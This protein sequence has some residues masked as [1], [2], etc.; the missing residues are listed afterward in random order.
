[1]RA[2]SSAHSDHAKQPAWPFNSA[3]EGRKYNM[4]IEY[5]Q[6][7]T[8]G[9]VIFAI[10]M[11]LGISLYLSAEH[12]ATILIDGA[13]INSSNRYS[14]IIIL[15]GFINFC[16]YLYGAFFLN[17]YSKRIIEHSQYPPPGSNI[18]FTIKLLRGKKALKQA[19]YIRLGGMFLVF[20]GLIKL[21][22]AL[23]FS[24]IV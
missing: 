6:A 10:L 8:K 21:C 14:Q 22:A 13:S 7:S 16:V 19:K 1:M 23:Y 5:Y 9:R 3:L 20:L 4:D 15:F 2:E 12:I 11:L 18:P 17:K 24:T